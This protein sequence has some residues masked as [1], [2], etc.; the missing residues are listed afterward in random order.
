MFE[1]THAIPGRSG[2][3]AGLRPG[4][5]LD[6]I[7]GRSTEKMDFSEA[8]DRLYGTPGSDVDVTVVRGKSVPLKLKRGV[9]WSGGKSEPLPLSY[10]SR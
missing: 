3:A 5:R 6:S 10:L 8:I 1:I 4:E 9:K 2:D 7:G